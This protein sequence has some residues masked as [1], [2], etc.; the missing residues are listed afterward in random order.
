MLNQNELRD[1]NIEKTENRTLDH[2]YALIKKS[3]SIKVRVI[4]EVNLFD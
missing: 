3:D 4:E 2:E 1:L